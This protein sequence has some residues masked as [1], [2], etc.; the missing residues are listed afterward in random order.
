MCA[1]KSNL[2]HL[3]VNY[4]SI[5][6]RPLQPLSSPT[7]GAGAPL[8]FPD[9]PGQKPQA[10][11]FL[12]YSWL[13]VW[14]FPTPIEEGS[15]PRDKNNHPHLVTSPPVKNLVSN[16]KSA[17]AA[18][19]NPSTTKECKRFWVLY[20]CPCRRHSFLDMLLSL[21]SAWSFN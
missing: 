14:V 15:P 8:R 7:P 3:R 17:A 18:Q 21:P 2:G 19:D 4:N 20:S 11:Y 1:L 16:L 13:H 12:S 6:I 9:T 10:P 5:L